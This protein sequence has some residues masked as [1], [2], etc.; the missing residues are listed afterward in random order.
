MTRRWPNTDYTFPLVVRNNGA[1]A[2]P[3]TITFQWKLGRCGAWN[4]VTPLNVVTA[5]YPTGYYTAVAT[6][7]WGGPL[8]YKWQTTNPA[9]QEEDMIMIE[10]SEFSAQGYSYDYGFGGYW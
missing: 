1:L 6:P 8:F 5:D 10:G 2:T 4:S 7:L 3:D 9:V